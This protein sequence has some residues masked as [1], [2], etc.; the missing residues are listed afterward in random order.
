MLVLVPLGMAQAYLAFASRTAG[1][2]HPSIAHGLLAGA[3]LL[4]C[5]SAVVDLLRMH[6]AQRGARERRF[7]RG[8]I[9]ALPQLVTLKDEQGRFVLVNRA[10]AEFIGREADQIIGRD[11]ADWGDDPLLATRYREEDRLLLSEMRHATREDTLPDATGQLRVFHSLRQPILSPDEDALLVLGVA[12]E[13]TQIRVA[14]AALR[15]SEER[16]R[17]MIENQGEG[18]G[19]VD[20]QERFTFANPA[21]ERIFGVP[22]GGLE[23]AGSPNSCRR[24]A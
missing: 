1:D 19:I 3:C 20:L 8:L 24:R 6:D 21:A 17:T 23:D 22:R 13:I 11:P 4:G 18:V 7:L 14:E 5:G 15:T 10:A 12:S 9:D 2:N 16:W